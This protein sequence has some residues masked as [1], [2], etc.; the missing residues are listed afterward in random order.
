[1][2]N[3]HVPF[4]IL[5]SLLV[6]VS[7]FCLYWLTIASRY[8][9]SPETQNG[10]SLGGK[11]SA[12]N[13][14][15]VR[16]DPLRPYFSEGD[17]ELNPQNIV[18]ENED[19][20][21]IFQGYNSP[22]ENIL[23]SEKCTILYFL[24][25]EMRQKN[26]PV[27]VR[28][29]EGVE[30][31]LG[32][33]FGEESE[34]FTVQRGILK[35][36]VTISWIGVPETKNDDFVMETSNVVYENN[37]IKS[38]D[39][40]AFRYG[41]HLGKGRGFELRL[42]QLTT[43]AGGISFSGLNLFEIRELEHLTLTL[44]RAQIEQQKKQ[45]GLFAPNRMNG[46]FGGESS[47]PV[48]LTCA[49]GVVYMPLQ[50]EIIFRRDVKLNCEYQNLPP[51]T[52]QCDE[53]I[54]SLAGESTGSTHP[55]VSPSEDNSLPK[56]RVERIH[57]SGNDLI[58]RSPANNFDA[59]GPTLD[60][61]LLENTLSLG[62]S[63]RETTLR[64]EN[65]EFHASTIVYRF[66]EN[67]S[68]LGF[69]HVSGSGWARHLVLGKTPDENDE[70]RA[71]WRSEMRGV[72]EENAEYAIY[73]SGNVTLDS[74][75]FGKI[76]SEQ[77][78][79]WLKKAPPSASPAAP[80]QAEKSSL[81]SFYPARIHALNRVLLNFTYGQTTVRGQFDAIRLWLEP[82]SIVPPT[83]LANLQQSQAAL[84]SSPT[85]RPNSA[86]ASTNAEPRTFRI[87]AE[88]ID[89]KIYLLPLKE[90]PFY[91]SK[92]LL[93]NQLVI[94]ED[95]SGV[96]SNIPISVTGSHL[97]FSDVLPN[98]LQ[99]RISG[100]PAVIAGHGL[101]LSGREINLNCASNRI[102]MGEGKMQFFTI[103]NG[104]PQTL[105]L[106]W[107]NEMEFDG[108]NL[109]ISK[110]IRITHPLYEMSADRV[111]G[112]L[113]RFIR[114]SDPPRPESF[115]G[116]T[117]EMFVS[118]ITALGS[119][120]VAAKM[121]DEGKETGVVRAGAGH[122]L[123]QP[124]NGN[125]EVSG[126]GWINFTFLREKTNITSIAASPRGGGGEISYGDET[127]STNN[128]E[129]SQKSEEKT[130]LYQIHT[131][132][133]GGIVGNLNDGGFTL[134]RNVQAHGD[135]VP[136]WATQLPKDPD[137]F[138]LSREGFI[139][140]TDE[141]NIN[142]TPD[143]TGSGRSADIEF[144]AEGRISIEMPQISAFGESLTYSHLKSMF[145]LSGGRSPARV[146][147]QKTLGGTIRKLEAQDIE[148]HLKNRTLKWYGA[149]APDAI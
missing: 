73:F 98:T 136:D 120:L 130:G 52:L 107:E 140:S 12:Q 59:Q 123:F 77:L 92:I 134:Y 60:I 118:R 80:T 4:R 1:M 139:L 100:E 103:R 129:E 144:R 64:M 148:I 8:H 72:P 143:L 37:S 78:N 94:A 119:V 75:R 83:L 125:F 40:I 11:T 90:N 96:S 36:R 131:D 115:A 14:H 146:H 10:S 49:E 35:G 82:L 63:T 48:R 137:P 145:L 33:A 111:V 126:A 81:G 116:Q 20:T 135:A 22:Q 67:R 85:S 113:V 68:D 32:T 38:D 122:A 5:M 66:A 34:K 25:E 112:E 54:I 39:V 21:L 108:Q 27:L 88:R 138:S 114:F 141:M 51:D 104:L 62:D 89:A 127:D 86:A 110:N 93:E 50:N 23:R 16:M 109:N 19:M 102:W 7:V 87:Q 18:V 101:E 70:I 147:Y 2:K 91:F 74:R 3:T 76:S 149:V 17:W 132:F 24:N 58:L 105:H 61:N 13:S 6:L 44:E 28:M 46:F 29:A 71:S 57:A 95:T 106:Q 9:T 43:T 56:W 128:G 55:P 65:Q 124:L 84:A 15:E 69:L 45:E 142:R 31:F 53:L 30:I 117:A 41:A 99:G 97:E 42:T 79:I 47:I 133:L 26:S 121:V